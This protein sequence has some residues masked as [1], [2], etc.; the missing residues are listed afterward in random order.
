MTT[1]QSGFEA[2]W[3]RDG[4]RIL[5]Y[6]SRHVG[7]EQAQDIVAETFT[8]AWRRWPVVPDPP[9]PWLIGTASKVIQSHRRRVWR[10]QTVADR[11]TLLTA[12]AADPDPALERLDALQRLAALPHDHQ[13]ALLLV[14]WDGLTADEAADVLGIAAATFRK[15]LQRARYALESSASQTPS[16]TLTFAKEAP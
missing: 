10:Q 14:A 5:A 6:A 4:P 16:L 13:E 12:V 3:R 15:R 11:L 7:L 9:L 2:S 1:R 8:V